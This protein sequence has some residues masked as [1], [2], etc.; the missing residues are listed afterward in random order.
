MLGRENGA[1]LALISGSMVFTA[2]AGEGGTV[3]GASF[4]AVP[5]DTRMTPYLFGTAGQAHDSVIHVAAPSEGA[6]AGSDG[7]TSFQLGLGMQFNRLLG[8][9]AYAQA[10]SRHAY[11]TVNGERVKQAA[12]AFGARVTLGLDIGES[13]RIFGKAGIARVVHS[14]RSSW[15]PT[16]D[17][18]GYSNRQSRSTLGLGV[19]VRLAER[20]SLRADADHIFQRRNDQGTGWGNLNHFGLG[21]Q[22][23]Y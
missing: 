16:A 12:R 19:S 23:R 15:S 21:L 13:L 9:E 17:E 14:G 11:L 2:H 5:V 1:L 8:A 22:Y 6:V 10:G 4:R 18:H 3:P 20:L 7:Q